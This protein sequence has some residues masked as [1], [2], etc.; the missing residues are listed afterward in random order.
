MSLLVEAGL[1]RVLS[2]PTSSNSPTTELPP[3]PTWNGGEEL[4]DISNRDLLYKVMEEE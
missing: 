2:E 4:V 1:R 3:L